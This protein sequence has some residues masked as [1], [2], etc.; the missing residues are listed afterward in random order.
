MP[1][2]TYAQKAGKLLRARGYPCETKRKEKGCG[3]VIE[4]GGSCRA[5]L[6]ILD[7]Y[8]IPFRLIGDGDAP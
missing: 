4:I 6:E 3:Y 5:A 1:S 7:R 8:G 2:F